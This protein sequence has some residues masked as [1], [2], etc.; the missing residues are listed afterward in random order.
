MKKAFF[1]CVVILLSKASWA[2]KKTDYTDSTTLKKKVSYFF[3]FGMG[4]MIGCNACQ[5]TG[6][7]ANFTTSSVHGIQIGKR[8]SLGA[9]VGFDSY[10][11][12]KTMPIFGSASFDLFGRKNKIFSQMNYGYSF[13][14]INNGAK[15][16]G[17]KNDR[18]G[19]MINPSLGYK[20]KAGTVRLSFSIGYKFQRVFS[21]YEYPQ[22]LN[23]E[24]SSVNIS[25]IKEIR[26]D[27]NRIVLGMTVGWK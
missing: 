18:G 1:I 5:S 2:E 17:Y 8:L 26:T 23:Y 12:W 4:A 3:T 19:E 9:G 25:N 6:N 21:H 20:I 13:A 7:V 22:W 11:N 24:I 16:Y 27:M 14:W 10:E 15:E